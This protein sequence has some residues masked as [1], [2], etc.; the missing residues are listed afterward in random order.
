MKKG[1]FQIIEI[2]EVKLTSLCSS[3]SSSGETLLL[4]WAA[5]EQVC[6]QRFNNSKSAASIFR[7]SADRV[8]RPSKL[9]IV[10]HRKVTCRKEQSKRMHFK[11]DHLYHSMDSWGS[12]WISFYLA[13]AL[14]LSGHNCTSLS[15]GH[16]KVQQDWGQCWIGSTCPLQTLLN[17]GL[18]RC[19]FL[20]SLK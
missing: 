2:S 16:L 18:Q 15:D 17:A 4:N 1:R 5:K 10:E 9:R 6:W 13:G 8:R 14:V 20:L 11:V 7:A 19:Q 3:W 12:A